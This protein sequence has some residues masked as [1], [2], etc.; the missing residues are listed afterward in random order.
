MERED[1]VL[2]SPP[3][4]VPVVIDGE[5]VTAIRELRSRGWGR[6]PIARELGVSINTVRRYVRQPLVAGQQVRCLSGQPRAMRS[7][8]SA[9]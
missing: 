9:C 8:C 1:G 2:V 4:G 3:V 6:K 7:S 5:I